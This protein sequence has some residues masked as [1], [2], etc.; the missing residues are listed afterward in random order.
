MC[1]V[2]LAYTDA[3]GN[4]KPLARGRIA[5]EAEGGE[6]LALGHA[7]PYNPDGFLRA[8]T[9]TYYGE[10]LAAVRAGAGGRV[11][12]R[13]RSPFG[14]A[15]AEIPIFR[16]PRMTAPMIPNDRPTAPKGGVGQSKKRGD[17]PLRL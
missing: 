3:A 1:F 6:L 11:V 14:S 5:V 13:A 16:S 2:R 8:D 4:K 12:V 9:D 15:C 17:R 10:A 7:C